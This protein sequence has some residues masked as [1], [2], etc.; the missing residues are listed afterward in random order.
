MKIIKTDIDLKE[1][2]RIREEEI[3]V[4]DDGRVETA[5]THK[6]LLEQSKVYKNLIE[7]TNLAEEFSY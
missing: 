1:S 4:I 7:K 6:Q 3:V 2:L 5:G